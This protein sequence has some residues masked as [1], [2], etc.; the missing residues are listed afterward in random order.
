MRTAGGWILTLGLIGVVAAL[1]MDVSVDGINNIGLIS[2]RQNYLIVAALMVIVGLVLIVSDRS[3]KVPAMATETES[4]PD[5]I[6]E[7][8]GL[9]VWE[10]KV[11]TSRDAAI[12]HA[13]QQ[14]AHH[15]ASVTSR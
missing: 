1:M 13:T 5:G 9:F 7:H 12:E 3:A 6:E 15:T 14:L 8:D 10:G 11:F 4:V 2:D